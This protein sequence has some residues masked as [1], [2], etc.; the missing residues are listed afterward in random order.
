MNHPFT[1][2]EKTVAYLRKKGMLPPP[3]PP[4]KPPSPEDIEATRK[5]RFHYIAKCIKAGKVGPKLRADA[6]ELR[7]IRPD[8]RNYPL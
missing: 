3:K 2:S 5:R 4:A 8:L 1:L 6:E 7:R